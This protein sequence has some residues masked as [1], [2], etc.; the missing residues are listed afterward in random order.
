MTLPVAMDVMRESAD[1]L[2]VKLKALAHRDRLLLLCH[3]T[4][5]EASVGE[6]ADAS[7]LRQAAV[8]QHLAVLR[9]AG[10]VEARTDQQSRIYSISDS[11]VRSMFDSLCAICIEGAA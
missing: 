8:S 9:D 6:L 5:G 4:A 3:L 11:Q 7:G 10:A 2:A 1:G